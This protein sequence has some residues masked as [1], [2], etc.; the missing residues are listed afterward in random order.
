M[1]NNNNMRWYTGR[2][3][4]GTYDCTWQV[5]NNFALLDIELERERELREDF[6]FYFETFGYLLEIKCGTWTEVHVCASD[7]RE[8]IGL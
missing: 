7:T 8:E 6:S 4:P 3:V 2:P 1:D 5:M